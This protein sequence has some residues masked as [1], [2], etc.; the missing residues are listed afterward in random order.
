MILVTGATGAVGRQPTDQRANQG[1][2]GSALTRRPS[3]GHLPRE[4]AVAGGDLAGLESRRTMLDG[5]ARAFLLTSGL[6]RERQDGNLVL[7]ARRAG[8]RHIVELFALA[9]PETGR[10]GGVR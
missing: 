2:S 5:V 6:G 3:S 8:G 1:A 4:V 9:V 10:S 7:A